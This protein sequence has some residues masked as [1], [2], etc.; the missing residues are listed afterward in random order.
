M[1]NPRE[2]QEQR[3]LDP[4]I[5][6]DETNADVDEAEDRDDRDDRDDEDEDFEPEEIDLDGIPLGDGPDA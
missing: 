5:E 3:E 4:E 1:P 2:E 6:V